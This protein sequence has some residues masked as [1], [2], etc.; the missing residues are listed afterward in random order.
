MQQVLSDQLPDEA[1]AVA[2][3]FIQISLDQ[4]TN[5]PENPQS[6]LETD[7]PLGDL[8]Q[9]YLQT[10][11]DGKRHDASQLIMNAVQNGT[12]IRD[13]YLY[14]FQRSQREIG[15]L[16]QLN[17]VSVAQEHFCTAATQLIMSQ[18]Y[19]Y[20]FNHDKNGRTLIATCVGN[21]LHEIGVRMVADFFEM[22]GWD[23]YYLGANTPTDS[24]INAIF[25]HQANMLAISATMTYH[26]STVT[27]LIKAVRAEAI[28][29][30]K[31]L[32]GGYPFNAS[33][34]LWQH[35]GADGYALD[36]LEAIN[37]ANNL[38]NKETPS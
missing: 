9:R 14:V 29:P 33:P 30:T 20:I 3:Q 18:L 35:V 38:I 23:T 11:L 10:L 2:H 31:V 28:H 12:E 32:V 15:R 22:A 34:Q 16:W 6:E 4:L 13:I 19:P 17:Q 7:N 24:I 5:Y 21:E 27:N 37:I 8:A 25:D 36:A 1:T 26:I